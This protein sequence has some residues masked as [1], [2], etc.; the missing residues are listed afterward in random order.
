MSRSFFVSYKVKALRNTEGL[1]RSNVAENY[2]GKADV[3]RL[4]NEEKTLNQII[5]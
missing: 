4:W 1:I 3:Q 5:N 2:F